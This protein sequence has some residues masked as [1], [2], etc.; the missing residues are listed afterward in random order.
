MDRSIATTVTDHFCIGAFL[1]LPPGTPL[2]AY[3]HRML[4]SGYKEIPELRTNLFFLERPAFP[5]GD[6]LVQIV[7]VT[8]QQDGS[9]YYSKLKVHID[10]AQRTKTHISGQVTAH[11]TARL[12][13]VHSRVVQWAETLAGA[14]VTELAPISEAAA[15][16]VANM[17][18]V[19]DKRL[20]DRDAAWAAITASQHP[21]VLSRFELPYGGFEHEACTHPIGDTGAVPVS[22]DLEVRELPQVYVAGPG[23]FPRLGAANPALTIL[24]TSQ[25]LGARLAERI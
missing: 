5:N 15:I 20:L 8:E 2:S 3:R 1:R 9:E 13:Q 23:A 6:R 4:W 11:D 12:V 14:T 17:P 18:S 7:A 25:W 22:P 10:T 21:N 16:R 24:A 19:E